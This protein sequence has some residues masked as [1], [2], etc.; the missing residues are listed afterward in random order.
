MRASE[1]CSR[2]APDPPDV[3]HHSAVAVHRP[4]LQSSSMRTT[5]PAFLSLAA[6]VACT[7]APVDGPRGL[8]RAAFSNPAFE[9]TTHER[10][11]LRIHFAADSYPALHADSLADLTASARAHDL[12]ILGVEHF[13]DT[14]DVF[15]IE[16]REQ[17]NA[18]AG[19]RVTGFA[20][21]DSAA[22][23][24]VTNPDWRGFERHELMHVI[25]H[26]AWGPAAQPSAWIEEGFAQ[27]ADG[28]CGGYDL[29]S[30]A[31]A[32]VQQNGAVPFTTLV[33]RFRE[34]DDLTA[35]LQASSM[36]GWL[37]RSHSVSSVRDVW[38]RGVVALPPAAADGVSLVATWQDDIAARAVP[39][40]ATHVARINEIGCGIA[41]PPSS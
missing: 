20:H 29:D 31:H 14:I 6:G 8:G 41:R 2:G 1:S 26:K 21:R 17:M 35:Y 37:V 23:L 7:Q 30:V 27:Y 38:Q 10:P 12:A 19:A 32:F 4:L 5:L 13:D 40:P 36:I 9:W 15:F 24:V 22:I 16:S 39:V 11:G 34:L 33:E 3:F 18:L 25:A 28:R